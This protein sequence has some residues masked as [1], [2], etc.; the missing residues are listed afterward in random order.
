MTATE[1]ELEEIVETIEREGV[2]EHNES[3]LI[4]SAMHFDDVIQTLLMDYLKLT[5]DTY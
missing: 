2:L 4:K 3:E 5:N 1:T